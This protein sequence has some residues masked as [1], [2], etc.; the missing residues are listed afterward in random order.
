MH[1]LDETFRGDKGGPDLKSNTDSK[2]FLCTCK[3]IELGSEEVSMVLMCSFYSN[4]LLQFC[5]YV[6]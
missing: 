1:F 6:V 5:S 3:E 4:K 2:N